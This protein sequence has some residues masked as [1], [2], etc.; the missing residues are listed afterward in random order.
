M[1]G[2]GAHDCYLARAKYLPNHL[3]N[4]PETTRPRRTSSLEKRWKRVKTTFPVR[5]AMQKAKASPCRP[6]AVGTCVRVDGGRDGSETDGRTARKRD[7]GAGR[8]HP[9]GDVPVAVPRGRVRRARG[10]GD[11]RRQ[12]DG[13]VG[14]AVLLDLSGRRARVR[15]GREAAP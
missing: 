14:W 9:G 7:H 15:A 3:S 5:I 6:P 4:K 11:V 12:V 1:G 10:V 8:A 13:G 2:K